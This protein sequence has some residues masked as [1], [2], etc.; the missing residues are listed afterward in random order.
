MEWVDKPIACRDPDCRGLAEP[1]IDGD[2]RYHECVDC[3][4]GFNYQ[5]IPSEATSAG[6]CAM[7]VPEDLRRRAS[8]AM[9]NTQAA[10]S[11][12]LLQIGRPQ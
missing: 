6:T 1:E 7:G 3:G 5:R 2:L 8:A 12:P 11:P 4:Y 9:E 10:T